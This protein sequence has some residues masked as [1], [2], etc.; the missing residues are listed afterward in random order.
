[1][2]LIVLTIVWLT[3]SHYSGLE[4]SKAAAPAGQQAPAAQTHPAPPPAQP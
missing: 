4:H 1:M 3:N 2:F